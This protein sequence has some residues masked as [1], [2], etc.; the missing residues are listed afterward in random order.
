[1]RDAPRGEQSST[2][3]RVVTMTQL[4]AKKCVILIRLSQAPSPTSPRTTS[5]PPLPRGATNTPS[6]L[7]SALRH[8]LSLF[9][10]PFL[11]RFL[12]H[13]LR[14]SLCILPTESARTRTNA[15]GGD[16]CGRKGRG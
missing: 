2:A 10:P 6:Q 3:V 11:P 1:M 15:Q 14:P 12:A 13:C 8:S 16:V 7:C 5:I 9:R 4:C